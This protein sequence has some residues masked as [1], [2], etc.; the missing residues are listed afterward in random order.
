MENAG[1]YAY[2]VKVIVILYSL[3]F[4]GLSANSIFILA[5]WTVNTYKNLQ[6]MCPFPTQFFP[7]T[8]WRRSLKLFHLSSW[9]MLSRRSE[10]FSVFEIFLYSSSLEAIVKQLPLK[11]LSENASPFTPQSPVFLF[12]VQIFFF[13]KRKNKTKL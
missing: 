12:S 11:V 13:E 9:L 5:C 7:N 1:L 3:L 4:P 8:K 2:I 10:F 6:G